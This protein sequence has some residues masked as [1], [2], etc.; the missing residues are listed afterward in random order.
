MEA[1]FPDSKRTFTHLKDMDVCGA[2]MN[3]THVR[4]ATEHL[5]MRDR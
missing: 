3:I 1:R 4:M 2:D 5:D